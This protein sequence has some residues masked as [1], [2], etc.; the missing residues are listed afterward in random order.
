MLNID[1]LDLHGET[2]HFEGVDYL[3]FTNYDTYGKPQ[4]LAPGTDAY[5]N[6]DQLVVLYVNPLASA[7]VRVEKDD[8]PA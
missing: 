5:D 6:D 7:A 4:I 3:L 2:H 1:V 8:I